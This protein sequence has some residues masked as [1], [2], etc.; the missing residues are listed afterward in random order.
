MKRSIAKASTVILLVLCVIFSGWARLPQNK[1]GQKNQGQSQGR[2]QGQ[3]QGQ[4]QTSLQQ[5]KPG[6]AGSAPQGG[7]TVTKEELAAYKAVYD[8]RGG[9]AAGIIEA[10]EKFVSQYPM[11][12]Y[13]GAVYSELTTAYLNANQAEKMM[14]AGSKALEANPDNVDVLPLMAWAMPRRVTSQTAD[15]PQQLQKAQGYAKH[16]IELLNSMP[17]P[18]EME[19][20]AFT[21]AKN[22]KLAMCHDGLGVAAVKT[23]K[24]DDAISELNQSVQ[25]SATPDLVDYYLLGVSDQLTS[26]FT[27]AI[28]NFTKCSAAGPLQA[29]CKAGLEETKKKAQNN[30]E[31]P[32]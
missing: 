27:D 24:Y 22:E 21:K 4:G 2:G 18:A 10:G 3:G 16:G 12:I 30:L 17:K 15:G 23:G 31:A 5:S 9:D 20:A 1:N 26:R 7:P 19:D 28:A 32:K 8:A 25:L 29:Q 6:E 14:N 11:S 13:V